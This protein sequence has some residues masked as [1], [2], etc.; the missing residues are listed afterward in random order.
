MVDVVLLAQAAALLGCI[1]Y[2]TLAAL[3]SLP[4]V[5]LRLCGIGAV[6]ND[7]HQKGSVQFFEGRVTHARKQPKENS[8]Q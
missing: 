3:L 4:A 5:F 1:A 8:F 6:D 2:H 7:K